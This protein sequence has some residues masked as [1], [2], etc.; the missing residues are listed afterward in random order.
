MRRLSY[1]SGYELHLCNP[2]S[3]EVE[4]TISVP[5]SPGDNLTRM[6]QALYKKAG[7]LGAIELQ[8]GSS[9]A[10]V[11]LYCPPVRQLVG[12]ADDGDLKSNAVD[13]IFNLV[14]D[15]CKNNGDA[16]LVTSTGRTYA[17]VPG[18]VT[19]TRGVSDNIAD[20]VYGESTDNVGRVVPRD[21][22]SH[23][24]GGPG[25][26]LVNSFVFSENF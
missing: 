11:P 7:V 15:V 5:E 24:A 12:T 23:A 14:W 22:S 21:D 3:M 4:D 8:I 2:K 25:R 1:H 19:S 9:A 10:S 6:T 26:A 17:L 16:W 20:D 13:W 18:E